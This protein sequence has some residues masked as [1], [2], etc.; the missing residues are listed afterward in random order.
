MARI[1]TGVNWLIPVFALLAVV[2][3]VAGPFYSRLVATGILYGVAAVGFNVLFGYTGL[4]SFGHAMFWGTGAYVVAIGTVKLSLGFPQSFLLALGVVLLLALVTG[5]LSLRHTKIYFA[6][7]TLAF[8]QLVYA[9][10]LKWRSVTGADEG[11]YGIPR[12]LGDIEDYYYVVLVVSFATL[13]LTWKLLRSPLGLAFRS[14]R[15]NPYRAEVVGYSVN[16]V[17]LVSFLVSGLVTGIAGALYSPLQSSINPDS[18]YWTFSA[19]IVFMAI[20]GGSRVFLGPFIGGLVYVFI[21]DIAMG[22]TEYWLLITGLILGA[23][24]FI[25]PSGIVGF[26]VKLAGGDEE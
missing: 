11:I 25:L 5:Y 13:F 19:A 24:I 26:I 4:L 7:L 10:A 18:L 2:P 8:S 1:M 16:R 15:D 21:Q 3:L 20:L 6:M 12:P 14:V 17:R 9:V 23:V 22:L